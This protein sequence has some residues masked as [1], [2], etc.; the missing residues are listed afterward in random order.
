V[1]RAAKE[2]WN[3]PGKTTARKTRRHLRALQAQA[4]TALDYVASDSRNRQGGAQSI[5]ASAAQQRC[6]QFLNVATKHAFLR[7]ST[8]DG[9]SNPAKNATHT[10]FDTIF[11]TAHD[12][13]GI[14]DLFGAKH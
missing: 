12:R 6:L 13:F 5:R 14:S 1:A 3:P 7:S 2:V 9:N 11:P 8:T 10:T 4:R